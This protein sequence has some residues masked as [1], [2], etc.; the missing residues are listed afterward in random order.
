[1][2]EIKFRVWDNE[3]TE[4]F[5]PVYEAYKGNLLD[6]SIGLGGDILRRTLEFP[7]EHQSMFPDKYLLEQYTGLKDKNGVEIY[8]GD[9]VRLTPTEEYSNDTHMIGDRAVVWRNSSAQFHYADFIPMDWGG[10]KEVEVI[11][12][13]HINKD[14]IK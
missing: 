4:Y 1:M 12:N 13:I 2:R 3:S 6:L 10:F 11:G 14:L 9:I 8:E 7:A 5:K